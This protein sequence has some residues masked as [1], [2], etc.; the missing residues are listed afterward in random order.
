[1]A[2]N[3]TTG[4]LTEHGQIVEASDGLCY[5]IFINSSG[6]LCVYDDVFGSIALGD[7]NTPTVVHGSGATIVR[8]AA[9]IDS[10]DLIHIVSAAEDAYI[11]DIAYAT[12]N[13]GTSTIGTWEEAAAYDQVPNTGLHQV[14]I[15][16]DGSDYPWICYEDAAKVH[17]STYHH[18]MLVEKTSGSWS[19]PEVVD[20]PNQSSYNV[21]FAVGTG[22][23]SHYIWPVASNYDYRTRTAGGSWGTINLYSSVIPDA[24]ELLISCVTVTSG[25]T[26]YRYW[27][28][29]NTTTDFLLREN[30]STIFSSPMVHDTYRVMSATA[31]A[32]DTR[33]AVYIEESRD[34]YVARNTG[35][36]WT[37]LGSVESGSYSRVW[38]ARNF[39]NPPTCLNYL[40]S[41]GTNVYAGQQY[42]PTAR[43]IFITHV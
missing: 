37:S 3:I 16:I 11:R 7:S 29:R 35:S 1:M 25:G 8:V 28:R 10:A 43:R 36:G 30:N 15:D 41:E 17:G 9:T 38:T 13:I 2:V 33:Y 20:S 32:D 18:G 31:V 24:S 12:Y 39:N 40:F 14:E 6:D 22:G 26:V 21:H 34:V 19:T 4:D 42:C 5:A 27:I 23:E